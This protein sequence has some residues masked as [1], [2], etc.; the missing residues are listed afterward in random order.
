MPIPTGVKTFNGPRGLADVKVN[1]KSVVVTFDDEMLG[2]YKFLRDDEDKVPSTLN[3]S[4]RMNISLNRDGDAIWSCFPAEGSFKCRFAGFPHAEGEE[5]APKD[6]PGA[7]RTG[8]GGGMY[9][10]QPYRQITFLM[11]ITAGKFEGMTVPVFAHYLF[12]PYENT[13]LAWIYGAPKK[14]AQLEDILRTLGLDFQNDNLPFSDNVL[15][16]LQ[17][18]LLDRK[19]DVLVRVQNGWAQD[20]SELPDGF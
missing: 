2:V 7:T 9:T 16:A 5:P 12:A 17:K 19:K 20:L 18:I 11:E 4:G 13:G 1:A 3:S 14:K 10:V 8:K 6:K 15:P